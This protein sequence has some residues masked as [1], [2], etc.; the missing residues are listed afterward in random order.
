MCG[1]ARCGAMRRDLAR[2]GATLTQLPAARA[3]ERAEA[4]WA[5][6]DPRPAPRTTPPAWCATASRSRRSSRRQETRPRGRLFRW[7]CPDRGVF[8][9]E[10]L[11]S[12]CRKQGFSG[13]PSGFENLP[14]PGSLYPE[15]ESRKWRRGSWEAKET[16]P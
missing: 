8:E 11:E 15:S 7:S 9:H 2:Y 12:D 4:P 16:A 1:L 5:R 10:A 6:K 3:S 13:S 14:G